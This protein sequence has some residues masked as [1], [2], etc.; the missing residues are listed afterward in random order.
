MTISARFLRASNLT[1]VKPLLLACLIALPSALHANPNLLHNGSLE[2][3]NQGFVNHAANYMAL[4]PGST[5]ISGWTVAAGTTGQIV[6]AKSPTSDGYNAAAGTYFVDLSGFGASSPNGALQQ[7]LHGLVV[8]ETYNV[9]FDFFGVASAVQVGGLS[10]AMGGYTP[11]PHGNVAWMLAYG[12]FV[13]SATDLLFEVRNPAPGSTV[14]FLDNL[15]VTAKTSPANPPA[16]SVPDG[17]SPLLCLGTVMAGF[18]A[19]ARHRR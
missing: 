5:T 2:D 9:A 4:G 10:V 7:T 1:A 11:D 3:T 13:A 6:W 15:S 19:L 8:G 18:V 16:N 14:V 12:S 17:G